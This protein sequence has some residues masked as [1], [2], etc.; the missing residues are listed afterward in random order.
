M[1][2]GNRLLRRE[3]ELQPSPEQLTGRRAPPARP[4]RKKR[5]RHLK[6]LGEGLQA[7]GAD[8]RWFRSRISEPAGTSVRWSPRHRLGHIEH[9]PLIRT[10]LLTSLSIGLSTQRQT[11]A[12]QRP[13]RRSTA[14]CQSTSTTP[15]AAS[16]LQLLCAPAKRKH[17]SLSPSVEIC[18]RQFDLIKD[19]RT[20]RPK[21]VIAN[22][23]A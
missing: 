2:R 18:R 12:V 16:P 6:D 21:S 22:W 14:F 7:T 9:E 11:L 10:R 4:R 8:A 1:W 19:S 17:R 3:R 20:R 23:P 13:L 5:N 15:S